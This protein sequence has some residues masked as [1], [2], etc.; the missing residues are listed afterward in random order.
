MTLYHAGAAQA[1]DHLLDALEG[2]LIE[3]PDAEILEEARDRGAAPAMLAERVRALITERVLGGAPP[4][5]VS[6]EPR[7]DE[8]VPPPWIRPGHHD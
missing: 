8:A 5:D 2:S 3:A 1:L 4:I 7:R 6:R